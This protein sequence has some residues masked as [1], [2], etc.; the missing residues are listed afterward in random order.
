[1][2]ETDATISD[3]HV[4]YGNVE[5]ALYDTRTFQDLV[6]RN[7]VWILECIYTEPHNIFKEKVR[8]RDTF[9]LDLTELRKSVSYE[10][11]RQVGKGK[12]RCIK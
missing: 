7:T 8:Y 12:R 10:V 6:R 5:A 9:K 2:I 11:S 4:N 3:E 1:V